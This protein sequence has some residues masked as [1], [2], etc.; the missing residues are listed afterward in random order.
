MRSELRHSL[1][2]QVSS[3]KLAVLAAL[4]FAALPV[5]A[6]SLLANSVRDR[7]LSSN[8]A[9]IMLA[10]TLPPELRLSISS[11]QLDIKVNDPAQKSAVLEIPVTSSW[12]LNSEANHVELIGFFDS[13]A[14][15]LTDGAGH[16]VPSSRVLGGTTAGDLLPFDES[17]SIAP[18]SASH[19]FYQQRI[20]RD[21]IV[22]RRT[23]VLRIQLAPINDLGA[24]AGEYRG[25]LHLRLIAY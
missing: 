7:G 20:S 16:A 14:A 25:V 15:A 10:A 12:V 21:N 24:P 3:R 13:P 19:T 23:D 17:S 2:T 5:S 8:K 6:Q 18:A 1:F 11:V 4:F 9:V 22:N